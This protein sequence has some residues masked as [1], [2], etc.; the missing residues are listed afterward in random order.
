MIDDR[1]WLNCKVDGR[2]AFLHDLRAD[3]PFEKNLADENADVVGEL[4]AKAVADANGEFPNFIM[5]LAKGQ[6]DA[7]GCSALAARV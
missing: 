2:G 7:P 3:A 4:F 1:W 6:A 5:D